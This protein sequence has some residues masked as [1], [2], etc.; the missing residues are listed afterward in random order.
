M[1]FLSHGN[2][3]ESFQVCYMNVLF[4]FAFLIQ[5]QDDCVLVYDAMWPGNKAP[6]GSWFN[7]NVYMRFEI[8]MTVFLK[9]KVVWDVTKC[10]WVNSSRYFK[11]A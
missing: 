10:R 7:R 3:N 4:F 6:D 9:I 5:F 2:L 11:G 1:S 8:L